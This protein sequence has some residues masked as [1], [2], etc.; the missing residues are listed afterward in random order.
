M[1]E[2]TVAVIVCAAGASS[3]F[4]RKEKKVFANVEGRALFLRSLERFSENPQVK[5]M[6]MA[7]SPEDEERVKLKWGANLSFFGVRVCLGGAE[8]FETVAR[9]LAHVREDIDLVAVHD[10]ARGCITDAWIQDVFA[11][12]AETGAAMLACPVTATIKRVIKGV[13]VETVDRSELWEAQTPQVFDRKL[14]VKAYDNLKNLDA[15]AISDDAMLVEA[16]GHKVHV[17]ETDT[18][19]WKVTY[20]A[21]TAVA[22]AIIKTRPKPKPEG[23]VGPYNEAQW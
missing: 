8:R 3:R 11:K 6:I 16:V 1:S 2:K 5:Q 22:E 9:A 23:P 17:V 13:I 4:G 14:L 18:S 15:A 19:N 12:A 20:P 10:A 7:I 21:D